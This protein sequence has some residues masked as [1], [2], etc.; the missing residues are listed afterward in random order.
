MKQ[1]AYER[2]GRMYLQFDIREDL[3]T[4]KVHLP[5]GMYRFELQKVGEECRKVSPAVVSTK[6]QN[7]IEFS[8]LECMT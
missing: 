1:H 4:S 5:P 3:S 2:D 7:A 6:R 8:R